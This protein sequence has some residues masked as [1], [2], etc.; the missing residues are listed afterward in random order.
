MSTDDGNCSGGEDVQSFRGGFEGPRFPNCQS[1]LQLG[2][3]LPS[4]LK[5]TE[6]YRSCRSCMG[7]MHPQVWSH[8]DG[9]GKAQG[10]NSASE[11]SRGPERPWLAPKQSGTT[12]E[13]E[14][15]TFF[16]PGDRRGAL[17]QV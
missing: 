16:G 9:L 7:L 15:L 6:A 4:S 17:T 12:T 11:I 5:L 1:L 13:M 8:V 2:E 14:D 3:A 10:A